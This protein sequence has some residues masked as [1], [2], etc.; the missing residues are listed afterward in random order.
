MRKILI[1]IIIVLVILAG[2]G[3]PIRDVL[4]GSGS[5]TGTLT[6]YFGQGWA[7][8]QP[9]MS[10]S[11]GGN[12]W[13]DGYLD[14][15]ISSFDSGDQLRISDNGSVTVSGSSVYYNG[16]LVGTVDGSRNGQNGNPL[17]I[18]FTG[19]LTNSGFETGDFTGWSVNQNFPQD[20]NGDTGNSGN[21]QTATVQQG[22][23]ADGTYAAQL[24]ISGGVSVDCGT[25]HGPE[26]TSNPFNARSGDQMTIR[27]N[28]VKG[29]DN[30][31][32]FGWVKNNS[33]GASQQL[34][35]SRGD[36]TGGWVTTTA[37]VDSTA[38]PSG[39]C[40]LSFV[41]LAGTQDATCGRAVGATMYVDGISVVTATATDAIATAVARAVDYEYTG[42]SASSRSVTIGLQ[43]KASYGSTSTT[44]TIEKLTTTT[45]IT[46]NTPNPSHYWESYTVGVSV[47][48]ALITPTGT[49]TVK[50]AGSTICSITLSGGSGSCSL[51]STGIGANQSLTADYGG[52][53]SHYGSSATATTHTILQSPT[54]TLATLSGHSSTVVYGER[55]DPDLT[56][57]SMYGGT[58]TGTGTMAIDGVSIYTAAA[59]D[60]SMRRLAYYSGY[61]SVDHVGSHT[62]TGSYSGDANNAASSQSVA[63]TVVQASTTT[64]VGT[65]Q[66]TTIYGERDYFTATVTEVAPS[67]VIPSGSVQFY[68]D[69][70]LFDTQTL[71]ASGQATSKSMEN[72]PIKP[73]GYS[74][75]A[76]YVGTSDF[77][78]ST[79]GT[80]TQ[81]INPTSTVTTVTSNNSSLNYGNDVIVT[82]TVTPNVLSYKIPV[83]TVL[84]YLNGKPYNAEIP[85]LDANGQAQIIVDYPLWW[86]QI[87]ELTA[88]YTPTGTNFLAGSL[89]AIYYQTILKN[90][91]TFTITPSV[92]SPVT[93]QSMTYTVV[94]AAPTS[95]VREGT[96]TGNVQFYVD[97]VALGSQLP[98]APGAGLTAT[99]TSTTSQIMSA[100]AHSI[101]VQFLGD[102][103]FYATTSSG[104]SVTVAS[105]STTTTITSK[106][107]SAAVVGQPVTV[108]F[109]VASNVP[110]SGVPTGTVTVSNGADTCTGTLDSSGLGSCALAATSPTSANLTAT[111]N[112]PNSNYLTSTSASF[113]G[114]V[115]TKANSTV[116]IT[117]FS[118]ASPKVGQT[119]TVN[120]TVSV[121][122]PGATAVT[123]NVTITSGGTTF[124]TGLATAG[125]CTGSYLAVGAYTLSASYPGNT[126]LN[127]SNDGPD[128][129]PTVVM[130][131]TTLS[132]ASNHAASIYGQ[133]VHFTA[134]VAVTSPGGGTP[135]GNVQFYIDSAAW[136]SPVALSGFTAV[137]PDINN[138]SVA[139]HTFYAVYL[140][141]STNYYGSTA[142]T[143]NQVVSKANCSLVLTSDLNPSTYGISIW[144]TAHLTGT[145][146]SQ[147]NPTTGVIQIIVDG[148][149]YGNTVALD[150]A[151][152]ALKQLRYNALIVGT[153]QVTATMT[154]DSSFNNCD[155]LSSPLNQVVNPG[156]VSYALTSSPSVPVYGQAVAFTVTVIGNTIT[157]QNP[158]GTIP[159]PTGSITFYSGLTS[160]GTFTLSSSQATSAT[161]S[162]LTAGT[163]DITGSY[164]GDGFYGVTV[165][166]VIGT[167]T[168]AKATT[169]AVI[170]S[171]SPSGAA[172][173][174]QPITV[175]YTVSA[176]SPGAGTPTGT[177]T[178]TRGTDTCSADATAHTC[179]LIPTTLGATGFSIS[180]AGDSNFLA[181]TTGTGITTG[182]TISPAAVNLAVSSI[183]PNTGLVYSQVYTVT[184]QFS[185]KSPSTMFPRAGSVTISNGAGLD[186][187]TATVDSTGLAT[188]NITTHVLGSQTITADYAATTLYLAATAT[189]GPVSVAKANITLT[190]PTPPTRDYVV[191]EPMPV[192]AHV[193]VSGLATEFPGGGSLTIRNDNNDSCA[194]TISAST[195]DATCSIIP[196]AAGTTTTLAAVYTASTNFNGNTMTP[197]SG[198]KV[199]PADFNITLTPPAGPYVYGQPHTIS[200]TINQVSPST[201]IPVGGTVRISN[202]D[203]YCDATITAPAADQQGSI[204]CSITSWTVATEILAAN[205]TATA[206]YNASSHTGVTGPVINQAVS[207]A[208]IGSLSPSSTAVIGQP[209]TVNFTVSAVSPGAG[210]P[211]GTVTITRGTDT[212]SA[213][214][215]A[216]SC[217]LIPTT[218]GATGFSISYAGDT[219]FLADTT[220]TGSAGPA[221]GPAAANLA[222]TSI[223]PN[224]GL[225]YSQVYT[226]TAQFSAKSPSTMFPRAGSVTIS[227]GAG[228]N[229]C[230]ASVDSTGLA[231]CDITTTVL[232]SQ[233]ITVDYAATTLYQVASATGGPVSVAKANITLTIPTPPT[234]DY[235]VGEPMPVTAHVA[236]SGLATEIPGGG[237]L[238]IRNNNND[239][240]TA[241]IS[242]STGDAACTLVPTAAGLT[243]TLTATYTASTNFNG[244]SVTVSGPKILPAD[245]TISLTPAAGPFRVGQPYTI[246]GTVTPVA[247]STLVPFGQTV[248]IS[249]GE[250]TCTAT[251]TAIPASTAGSISCDILPLHVG[252]QTVSAGYTATSNYNASSKTGVVGPGI[253]KG[254]L[255][256]TINDPPATLAVG[257][258][259]TAVAHIKGAAP[260]TTFPAGSTISIALGSLKCDAVI[261]LNGEASCSLTPIVSGSTTLSAS[262]L[263]SADYLV[264]SASTTGPTVTLAGVV[265]DIPNPPTGSVVVGQAF[266]VTA[267]VQ[268][269]LP[270]TTIPVG[271]TLTISNGNESCTATIGASGLATCDIKPSQAVK[272]YLTA[273]YGGDIVSY[274]AA[275]SSLVAGVDVLKA[276]TTTILTTT[277]NPVLPGSTL[278]FT[279]NV[280]V[281]SP[282]G[283]VPT[284]TVTFMIDGAALGTPVTIVGGAAISSPTTALTAGSHAVTAVYNGDSNYTASPVA[285]LSQKVVAADHIVV[286]T[287]GAGQILTVNG[288]HNGKSVTTTIT[289]PSG[290]VSS[291]VVVV[292]RQF[293]GSLT[294]PPA[295]KDL[296]ISF[297]LDVYQD[298]VRQT[299]FTFLKPVTVAVEYNQTGLYE[300]ALRI[301]AYNGSTWSAVA[302]QSAP[303]KVNHVIT[304]TLSAA[305]PSEYALTGSLEHF[306]Y[307]P[308]IGG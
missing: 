81:V 291:S 295:G 198:P 166:D 192:T 259:F 50:L 49:V 172:V 108:N 258:A 229:S 97:A 300:S 157:V 303:D 280:T 293:T 245:F 276:S 86:P 29:G 271:Q 199:L 131:S 297:I 191:G 125:S 137:S 266:T 212:C 143:Q 214:A 217:Q 100:G 39:T 25:A 155:N 139:T 248:T 112:T 267:R 76:T 7:D 175:N 162:S 226:V 302:T 18:N 145:G 128:A 1:S 68:V 301:Q 227:N 118:P 200:G 92:T 156:L 94:M 69:G 282:G 268:R 151:G 208:V 20:W 153:H 99:A 142:S 15:A 163:H 205:Y 17:R 80:I 299:A 14:F 159:N 136:G 222:V 224:S 93:G 83:G 305:G 241:T 116:T 287:P 87:H 61:S 206:N 263:G 308:L 103:Y 88:A 187:C 126:N 269:V 54:T 165:K 193:A 298:G 10:V 275:V 215:S 38:C 130:A 55:F 244:S 169:A 66:S 257:E 43:D 231:T 152:E 41:F 181:D 247:P 52:D 243:T 188:C 306:F 230:T 31:D 221:V 64:S 34:F 3:A 36:T 213:L 294:T 270:S 32:V 78:A 203:G 246:S 23:V 35:Y 119:V 211:T 286:L 296:L 117:G 82:I 138:L 173:V 63:F 265:I 16:N 124:C 204:S 273:T 72:L 46:T 19:S 24:T 161:I 42:S 26:I 277:L 249:N 251:I 307:M 176:V 71:N 4:A 105:A 114:P 8:F 177:V 53:S 122:S 13:T 48:S 37:S 197:V 292:F 104:K 278:T 133:P 12:N 256:V 47:S 96:P 233:T 167:V 186:S 113:S 216:L 283:F 284:G 149:N 234:R 228:L 202:P 232:G 190:I 253:I 67:L 201:L 183:T 180:Y 110:G 238:T 75:Y 236:V 164:S 288:T 59:W 123:N 91:P 140:G 160:L 252:T 57:S 262:F 2:A 210:T 255:T 239:S 290:A 95:G 56:T 134:T 115:V 28:A 207:A 264:A 27:W 74:V 98:L 84:L 9:S 174:G 85:T 65:T 146:L 189:G 235:V 70:A 168:V 51:H 225:V 5:G 22:T 6:Y 196:T 182:P 289:L 90:Y 127:G 179:Q 89:S 261:D 237:S 185:A 79:S 220:G 274:A 154:G 11:S 141:D 279:A 158:T 58:I 195:G 170:N 132:V 106:S 218:L 171:L 102:D 144:I 77:V 111:Y 223:T 33:S 135:T 240:C 285:A 73:A 129:G 60:G 147:L 281:D 101:T 209:I 109:S 242:A 30:Y 272:K 260:T 184:A 62:Y 178:I 21:S 219:N 250:T 44:L 304:C 194:A 107:T 150:S 120:Y 254:L 45:S 40:S 148:I 121:D